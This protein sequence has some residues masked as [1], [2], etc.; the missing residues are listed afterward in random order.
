MRV[1]ILTYEFYVVRGP[2]NIRA[3]FKKS[4]ACSSIP[5][6]KF[7]LGYAFGL[8]RKALSLYDKDDSGGGHVPHPGRNVLDRN[9]ID[10]RVYQSLLR[11]LEGPGLA[12]FFNRFA[13]NLPQQ[14]D[15]LQDGTGSKWVHRDDLMQ[16][17]GDVVTIS[18]L[19]ALCG[20]HLLRLNPNFLH[21]FWVFDR[22]LQ[23][24]LQGIPW[25]LAPMAYRAR[26]RVLKA[27][28]TWQQFARDNFEDSSV[29]PDGDDPYWGTNF[30]RER[31]KMFLQM[32]GFDHKA[33]ASAD[34]GAIWA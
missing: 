31:H 3:L 13:E 18:T 22:N 24:Y 8:P 12:P 16:T 14:L 33:I 29:G 17:V 11:F 1:R 21:D 6:V 20:P 32:D 23:T 30:F 25:L 19:D 27:V 28:Q 2:E 26:Q 4:W 10:Y 15:L 9:R 34:L 7:A 5:F